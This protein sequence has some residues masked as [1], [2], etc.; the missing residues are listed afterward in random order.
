MSMPFLLFGMYHALILTPSVA[1]NETSSKFV[2]PNVA[3]VLVIAL[4]IGRV[5]A[6]TMIPERKRGTNP[7]TK[8]INRI[9][10]I[11]M[12][13]FNIRHNRDLRGLAAT[14]LAAILI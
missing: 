12:N 9:T 5:D 13:H 8:A 11:S 10:S 2:A 6:P 7:N 4:S 14:T 3:G 1:G